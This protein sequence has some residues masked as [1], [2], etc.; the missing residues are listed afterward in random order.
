MNEQHKMK[1]L[2]TLYLSAF[3]DGLQGSKVT[4]KDMP[5]DELWV[6]AFGL[7]DGQRTRGKTSEGLD[8]D[9]MPEDFNDFVAYYKRACTFEAST[10]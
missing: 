3:L 8:G 9:W 4:A 7:S 5:T 1:R 6:V 10:P 2:Y